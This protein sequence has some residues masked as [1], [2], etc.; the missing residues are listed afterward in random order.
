MGFQSNL[1]RLRAAKEWTQA[2]L[3]ERSGVPLRTIQNYEG[4]HRGIR[5]GPR[6][7][8]LKK[9]AGALGVTIDALLADEPPAKPRGR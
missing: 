4:G 3:A 6:M 8:A 7:D 1:Q 9:L 2:E 5:S